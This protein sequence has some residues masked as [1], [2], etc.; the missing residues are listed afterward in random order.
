[1]GDFRLVLNVEAEPIDSAF[2]ADRSN[3]RGRRVLLACSW[4]S[5]HRR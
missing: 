3:G 4:Q 5:G 1:M 2:D